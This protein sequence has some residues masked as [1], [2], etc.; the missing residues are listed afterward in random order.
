MRI[1]DVIPARRDRIADLFCHLQFCSPSTVCRRPS[2]SSHRGIT[3]LEVLISIGVVSVGVLG[4]A[5]MLPMATYFQNETTN[6][7]RGGALAQQAVHDLEVKSYLSPRRWIFIDPSNPDAS[8]SGSWLGI[9]QL[10]LS[11]V[12]SRAAFVIDPLGWAYAA[13]QSPA[14]TFPCYFPAFPQSAGAAPPGGGPFIFRA[15]ITANDYWPPAAT[16]PLAPPL[17]MQF[18]VADRLMRSTDDV[19]FEYDPASLRIMKRAAGQPDDFDQRPLAITNAPGNAPSA[20]APNF[21]GEYSWI[22]TVSR[23][24]SDMTQGVTAAD[25]HRFQ[26]TVVVLQNRDLTLWTGAG[27]ITAE[28]PPSERQVYAMFT[29][30]G[31]MSN[32]STAPFYGGGG[33]QLYVYEGASPVAAGAPSRHWLDNIKPNTYLMLTAPF[34]DSMDTGVPYPRLGW[35]RI[36][37]V[38]DGPNQDP[39]NSARWYRNLTVAGGDWPALWY[40]WTNGNG[41]P[42]AAVTQLWLGADPMAPDNMLPYA[43]AKPAATPNQ[44]PVAYCTLMTGSIAAYDEVITLDNSLV[45]E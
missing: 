6:Y 31:G 40:Q 38:D 24:P 17:P 44:V 41:M 26:V 35:Y 30:Y 39:N 14:V 18:S 28:E 3:L 15:G 11:G 2:I 5:T 10:N 12:A 8:N 37:N 13:Q 16:M 34:V 22:A 7:D 4:A 1:L 19:L 20:Y 43:S 36:T 23:V 21:A 9:A 29:Q 45:H 25:L 42:T 33:L 27:G 32:Q